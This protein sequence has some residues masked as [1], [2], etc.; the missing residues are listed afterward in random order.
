VK[1]SALLS[2]LLPLAVIAAPK[3]SIMEKNKAVVRKFDEEFKV[4]GNHNIIDETHAA[5]CAF[6]MPDPNATNREALKMLGGAIVKAFPD[7]KPVTEE[8]LAIDDK[9]IERTTVTA[10]HKGEFN[11]VPATGRPV[12]WTEL[13]IYRLKD[14]RVV[15]QWSEI[16]MLGILAQIGA[17]PPPPAKK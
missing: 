15:E 1:H 10:T 12:R 2:L 7:V 3:E 8:L 17:L 13:H 9:V 16:N 6:H 14:G 4:K 11:G 5:D